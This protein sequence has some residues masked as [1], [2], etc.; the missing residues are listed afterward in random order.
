[1]AAEE[2]LLEAFRANDEKAGLEA[3]FFRSYSQ[4]S[5]RSIAVA[6]SLSLPA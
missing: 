4:S 2:L 6:T 1:V 5:S 3:G